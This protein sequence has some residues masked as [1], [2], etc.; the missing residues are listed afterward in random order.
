MNDL[1]DLLAGGDAFEDFPA[2]GLDTHIFDE[3]FGHFKIDIRFQEGH[4]DFLERG[5][6][7]FLV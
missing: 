1:D 5:I 3:I 6:D 4:A 2:H 7:I